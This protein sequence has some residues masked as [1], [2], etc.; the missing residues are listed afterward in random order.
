M[1]THGTQSAGR[2][3]AAPIERSAILGRQRLGQNEV[4]EH[5]VGEAQRRG[6]D[7]RQAQVDV[8]EQPADSGTRDEPEAER[9][10][11]VAE[12]LG[13][14]LGRRDVGKVSAGR[15]ERRTERTG[16]HAA[17]GKQRE[18]GSER[19][20]HVVRGHADEREQ[21]H[22]PPA[23]AVGQRP[24]ERRE[25]ELHQRVGGRER[26]IDVR[27]PRHVAALELLDEPRQHGER[28]PSP[29]MSM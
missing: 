4:C 11:D 28:E 19:E 12:A 14:F 22:G 10:A 2:V 6:D 29:S 25:Q 17:D 1:A 21:Q 15:R 13:A 26:T 5:E 23:V 20:Q 24:Q 9:R 18:R 3:R 27:R 7:E 8:A 16:D